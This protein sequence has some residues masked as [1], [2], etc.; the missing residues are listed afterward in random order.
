MGKLLYDFCLGISLFNYAK[1]LYTVKFKQSHKALATSQLNSTG[2]CI[3]NPGR[4]DNKYVSNFDQVKI[5]FQSG[6]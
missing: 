6:I 3:R 1:K 2:N 5:F 4:N